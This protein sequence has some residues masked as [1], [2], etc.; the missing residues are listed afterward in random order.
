[1][2]H[3]AKYLLL[4]PWKTVRLLKTTRERRHESRNQW[5]Q[6]L[7]SVPSVHFSCLWWDTTSSLINVPVSLWVYCMSVL[8]VLDLRGCCPQLIRWWD[9]RPTHLVWR[10]EKMDLQCKIKN[11][12]QTSTAL[13]VLMPWPWCLV[14]SDRD[15]TKT[16]TVASN[17]PV[18]NPLVSLFVPAFGC[19]G[20]RAVI[21]TR[22]LFWYT[23]TL[24]RTT[25]KRS[26]TI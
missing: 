5:S 26:N 16:P 21:K 11:L 19:W 14:Y 18:S 24:T 22:G 6:S 3:S 8:V 1:M 2:I 12:E 17:Q 20:N 25:T 23:C 9:V 15:I 4:V 10:L 7:N 13:F